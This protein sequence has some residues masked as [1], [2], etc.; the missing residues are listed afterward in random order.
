MNALVTE[1]VETVAIDVA[2]EE[3]LQ[4]IKDDYMLFMTR[5]GK[6]PEL[7]ETR[8]QM[9]EEFN[10]ELGYTVGKKYIKITHRNGGSVWGFVVNV[11]NDK[12]F[13]FGDLLMAAGF[14]A[15]A[16]NHARGNVFDPNYKIQ[17]TGPLYITR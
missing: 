2:M 13:Q 6:E 7:T 16:R 1:T 12:K 14:N 15:P 8:K 11:N 3:L 4:R 5:Y 9:I 17:W 10:N